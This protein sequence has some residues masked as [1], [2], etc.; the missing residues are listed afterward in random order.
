[1]SAI[2]G[3]KDKPR[4]EDDALVRGLG[5]FTDDPK[6]P[7]QAYGAFVRSPHAHAKVL[8]IDSEAALKAKGVLA[9]LTAEDIKAAGIGGISRH[10]PA[11]GRG[12]A[13]MAVPFRPVLADK[14]MHVGD[15]VALVVAETL[16]LALDA[17]D[18]VQVDYE[19]L[20]AVVELDAAMKA[21]T[22][23]FPDAPGNLCVDWAG[24]VPSE[25]NEREVA[26]IFA[27]APRVA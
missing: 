11:A 2:P 12:G 5:N 22:Q 7:N 15:A 9:V 25:D 16:A 27:G 8:K 17:A 10:P 3:S 18:L 4:V 24:P 20:P 19:E 6:L 23:L 1:M 21:E 13:K 14:P 26:K